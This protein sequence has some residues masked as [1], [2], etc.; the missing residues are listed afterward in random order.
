MRIELPNST[1]CTKTILKEAIHAPD[2]AFTLI[3]VG[4]LDNTKCSATFSGGMC[5]I[6][7]PS[8]RTMATIPCTNGLYHV[9][10][11]EDP[12]TVNYASIAMVK[13]TISKAHQK[14]GHIAP[15]ATKYVIA[16]GHI[17]GIQLDPESK[18]EFCKA[19]AKAKAARQPFPKESE[20]CMTK[21]GERVHWDLWGPASVRSLS[22]NLY[23]AAHIDNATHET[24][25]YFQVKKSQTIKS[26]KRDEALIETQTGNRIKVARSD[27]GG[28]FL[29]DD[30]T[31]HQDM[32]GTKCELTVHDSP[33]QNGIAKCRMCTRAEHARALLL[34]SGL[35]RF[36]WEEAMKHTMWLQNHTPARAID[37]KTLYEMQHKKKPHL[38]GIQEFGVAAY[39][40]DLKAGKLD[41]HA[42]VGRFVGYDLES[43][44]YWIYWPQK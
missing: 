29:S 43:K 41:A 44:G 18:P 11:P 42:K 10:A 20:T 33:Q 23:M 16:K 31:Q 1:K 13:L 14:L 21:Y 24:V 37:R 25:L 40:K 22:G 4:R 8:S 34:A 26:Y 12:P 2:M 6:R 30:L 5:T 17:T 9:T 32:R 36:L 38:A 7:N 35:L 3:L 27:R 28:E 19:C 15:S 39:V